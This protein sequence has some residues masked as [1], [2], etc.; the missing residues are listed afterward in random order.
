M[1]R[2]PA[3]TPFKRYEPSRS[4]TAIRSVPSTRTS[5]LDTYSACAGLNTRPVTLPTLPGTS[6]AK[7]AVD[8][9]QNIA[10]TAGDRN[11]FFMGWGK[12]EYDA[13]CS[14]AGRRFDS[15]ETIRE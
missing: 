11:Q 8:P 15:N 6:A 4:V 13:G 3:G 9:S 5:A 7:N 2:V 12:N 14:T 1:V 10:T